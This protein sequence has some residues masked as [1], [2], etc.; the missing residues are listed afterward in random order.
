MSISGVGSSAS[1]LVQSLAD[2]RARLD[3]L[4]RQLGSGKK[5]D[6]YAGLGLDRGLTVGLRSQL[7]ALT[8]YGDTIANVGVR[9][10]LAQSVIGAIGNSAQATK[11][12]MHTPLTGFDAS[13]QTTG[14]RTALAQ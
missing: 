8:A 6:T 7:S 10:D 12:A 14:Q 5:A 11:N 3:E 1:L 13:G 2:M 4:Q 9:L